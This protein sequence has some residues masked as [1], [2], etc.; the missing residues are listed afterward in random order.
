MYCVFTGRYPLQW[1]EAKV[2]NI[3][4]KGDR[5]LPTNYRGISILVALAKLYDSV[6]SSRF[7]L[8]Y[9]PMYAQAGSQKGRGCAEQILCLRL[10]IDI[11]RSKRRTLYIA[12]VD[13]HKAYDCV[14]RKKL[15]QYL[16]KR[17]CGTA[18]LTAIKDSYVL[19]TGKI[20]DETF[21]ARTGVRQGSCSSCP[22]F[23]FFIEPTI[24][25]IGQIGDDGWLQGLHGLLL[26]DDTVVFAT[27][28]EAMM[29]KLASL[30]TCIDNIGLRM[31][32]AKSQFMCVN[33]QCSEPFELG[34]ITISQTDRY[35]YLGSPVSIA[36]ISEQVKV[37]LQ[38][39]KG[40]VMKFYSF[41]TKNSEAPYQVKLKVWKSAA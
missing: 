12:F 19:T 31:N 27:S 25:A 10:I 6:L 13:Y 21:I 17:G 32:S 23:T 29:A 41:L 5:L 16:D 14:D 7:L 30:K 2:F 33:G 22:L 11:A 8:W 28:R 34:D 38:L 36:S 20:G 3:F 15:L 26:M 4:K 9:K 1:S 40:Q 18:F 37:H 35:T 24:E 39:K